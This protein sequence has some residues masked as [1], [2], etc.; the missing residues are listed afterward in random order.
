MLQPMAMRRRRSLHDAIREHRTALKDLEDEINMSEP[1][2]IPAAARRER[3]AHERVQR[4]RNRDDP[5]N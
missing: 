1:D 5:R 4:L 2:E 3:E